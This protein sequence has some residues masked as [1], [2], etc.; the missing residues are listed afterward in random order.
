M[1]LIVGLGNPGRAYV[2]SRHNV[3]FQCLDHF[4][5][6]HQLSFGRRRANSRLATGNINGHQVLL[7][8]PQ[9][10][11]NRSGTSVGSLVR[12]LHLPL[13][14]L[15]VVYDD[16]NLPLGKIR[17]RERGSAG[18]HNGMKSIIAALGGNQEFPRIR[19]GIGRPLEGEEAA[20]KKAVGDMA[21]YVLSNFGR[22]EVDSMRNV[23]ATAADA[24]LCILS[25]GIAEAMN[26]YN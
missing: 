14:D 18:G 5:K 16:L 4:A 23:W 20:S 6:V 12:Y 15:L 7:A 10:F 24:V 22:G 13:K 9:T 2:H 3:G 19:I 17:I 1:K 26:R 11:M 8:K 21:H 25:D